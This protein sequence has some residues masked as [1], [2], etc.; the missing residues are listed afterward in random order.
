[1]TLLLSFH[2]LGVIVWCSALWGLIIAV[3]YTLTGEKM[4]FILAILG[5]C[6]ALVSGGSMVSFDLSIMKGKWFYLKILLIVALLGV[7]LIAKHR[8]DNKIIAYKSLM[9]IGVIIVSSVIFLTLM[10]PF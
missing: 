3:K 5:A 9:I 8:L 6:C 4:L 2:L 7:T 1:M 10:R